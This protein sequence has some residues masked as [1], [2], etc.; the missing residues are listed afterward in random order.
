[1]AHANLTRTAIAE[2]CVR[3]IDIVER[4]IGMRGLLQPHPIERI[5]RDLTLYLR[6]P[7]PDAAIAG[8]GAYVLDDPRP[9][10]DLWNAAR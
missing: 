10:L 1:V 8:A 9:I 3:V 5:G 4:S 6:Q 7:A 2:A